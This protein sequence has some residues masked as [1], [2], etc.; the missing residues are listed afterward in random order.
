MA[1][2]VA[3]ESEQLEKMLQSEDQGPV[4][5]VNL[6]RFRPSGGS[7]SFRKYADVFRTMLADIGGRFLFEGGVEQTLIGDT[8]H[9]VAL[10]EYP[11]R[12]AF[13]ELISSDEFRAI[14]ANREDGLE[15]TQLLAAWQVIP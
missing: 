10:V 2:N 9:A 15:A 1:Q 3:I 4:V 6:L 5:M 14:E 12:K 8:W 7:K 11:S 13:V